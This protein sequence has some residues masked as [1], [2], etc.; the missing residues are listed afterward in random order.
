MLMEG[1][2]PCIGGWHHDD[3]PRTREDGQPNYVN[4]EY[5]SQH[6]LGLV[7][8]EISP[9]KF[10]EGQ[11]VLDEVP[12]GEVVYGKWHKEIEKQLQD[13]T[14]DCVVRECP[15][16]RLIHFDCDD[17]HSGQK[18]VKFGWRWFG[19]LTYN[20][21]YETGHRKRFNEIRRQVNVYLDQPNGG[22]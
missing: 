14:K 17:F 15:S 12:L 13:K 22:W 1:W 18:A 3:V 11:V 10:V 8:G 16:N 6:I 4:P 5:R 9:T 2:T 21:G 20:A 19:R 7:N